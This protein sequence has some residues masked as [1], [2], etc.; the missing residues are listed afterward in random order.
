MRPPVAIGGVGG[1]GTR[2]IAEIVNRLGY[3]IGG[4]LNSAADNLWFTLLFKRVELRAEP[5][6]GREFD[7]AVDVFRAAMAGAPPLTTEQLQWVRALAS[8]DRPQH[9]AAWLGQRADS[10]AAAAASGVPRE[11]TRC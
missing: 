9:D 10:L 1:S 4:D 3:Y 2:L 8:R 6:G 11:P 5:A 7:G